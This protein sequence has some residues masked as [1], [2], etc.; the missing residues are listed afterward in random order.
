MIRFFRRKFFALFLL[1]LSLDLQAADS[2]DLPVKKGLELWFDCSNQN[3]LRS[4]VS[5]APSSWHRKLC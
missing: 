5:G 3:V 1:L 2:E 4:S